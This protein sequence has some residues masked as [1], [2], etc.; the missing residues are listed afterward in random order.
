V[1]RLDLESLEENILHLVRKH[2]QT[3]S[4]KK[5]L[6]FED[7]KKMI[8]AHPKIIALKVHYLKYLNQIHVLDDRLVLSSPDKS[9]S[10]SD[11]KILRQ[12]DEMCRQGE[13]KKF[14]FDELQE[15][16]GIPSDRFDRL[17]NVLLERK[18]VIHGKEG[19]I[20]FADWL[21]QLISI[22][23]QSKI[24]ELTVSEF[25]KISGLSRKYAIPLL[26][27]LDKKGIT[28]KEGSVHKI[29]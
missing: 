10:K 21:E 17:L 18:K 5:G 1:S 16:L 22:L 6:Y 4:E 29:L 13:F 11:E 14:S 24:R 15:F 23:Q 12:M 9:I 27:L 26:E 2:C 8:D 3:N 28:R 7:L 20:F 25:K 19:Y